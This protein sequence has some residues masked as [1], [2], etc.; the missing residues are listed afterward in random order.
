MNPTHTLDQLSRCCEDVLE[1]MF[2]TGILAPSEDPLEVT[3][4]TLSACVSFAGPPNGELRLRIGHATASALAASFLGIPADEVTASL[5]D[6][7]LGE[8]ANMLCGSFLTKSAPR[9]TLRLSTP[10]VGNAPAALD[11]A[12]V[13]ICFELPEGLLHLAISVRE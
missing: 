6:N 13:Q 8:L 11:D 5:T 4:G 9:S 10:Q 2:F 1:T 7:V 3:R 12:A